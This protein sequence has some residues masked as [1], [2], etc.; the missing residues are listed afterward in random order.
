MNRA[1]MVLSLALLATGCRKPLPSPDF[2]EASNRYTDLVAVQ[3]DAAYATGEMDAVVAQL[4]RVSE[5]SSD[6]ASAH[7]LLDTIAKERTRVAAATAANE[8][9]LHPKVPPPNFPAFARQPEAEAVVVA[10]PVKPPDDPFAVVVG[11]AWPPLEQKFFGCFSSRGAITLT[12]ADGGNPKETE[13]FELVDDANCRTRVPALATSVAMIQDGKVLSIAPKSA[14]VTTAIPAPAARPP[15]A[16]PGAN[17]PPATVPSG[18]TQYGAPNP[19]GQPTA[20][21][22]PAP[23]PTRN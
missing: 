13:G 20:P 12:T 19:Y 8:K 18:G 15:V 5:K 1:L 21:Q 7:T 14:V 9:L 23:P 10:A 4:T 16:L 17:P 22:N 6:Y 11:A 2:I 3:S